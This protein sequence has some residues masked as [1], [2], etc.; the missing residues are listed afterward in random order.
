MVELHLAAN[1]Y[2]DRVLLRRNTKRP[3][4]CESGARMKI[5]SSYYSLYWAS[6]KIV[7]ETIEKDGGW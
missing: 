4:Y 6:L 2:V 1:G 3:S 5:S 7:G